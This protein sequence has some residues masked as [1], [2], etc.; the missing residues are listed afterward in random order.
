[1]PVTLETLSPV[2]TDTPAHDATPETLR[3]WACF[4]GTDIVGASATRQIA[5]RLLVES[6]HGRIA[7][8]SVALREVPDTSFAARLA[9]LIDERA[10][11]LAS[12]ERIAGEFG[13][14][15]GVSL[16]VLD[17]DLDHDNPA[18]NSGLLAYVLAASA[19]QSGS[20]STILVSLSSLRSELT[21]RLEHDWNAMRASFIR[22]LDAHAVDTA[23][24]INGLRPSA[25]NYLGPTRN[26]DATADTLAS[27]VATV[28]QA[29]RVREIDSLR[30][31]SSRDSDAKRESD[32]ATGTPAWKVDAARQDAHAE[33]P[34][35]SGSQDGSDDTRR[36]NRHQALVAFPFLQVL[37]QRP[38]FKPVCQ[39][40]D[41]GRPLV[42]ALADH[43]GATRG[44]IRT[45]HGV[46]ASNLG[47][48]TSQLGILLKLLRDL[49]SAWWPRDPD[50]WRRF[51]DTVDRIVRIS[52]HPITT[53]TN[54]LWLRR[55]LQSGGSLPAVTPEDLVRLGRDIDEFLDTL[56]AAIFSQMA[57]SGRRAPRGSGLASIQVLGH[58]KAS[59]GLVRLSELVR[60]FGDA[61]LRAVTVFASQVDLWRGVRWPA[62]GDGPLT[63]GEVRLVPLLTPDDLRR[64][65][66]QMRNCVANYVERCAKGA[67]QFW[68]VRH[69]D[70]I[71]LSTLETHLISS[72]PGRYSLTIAQ[73]KGQGNGPVPPIAA[74]AAQAHIA[75]LSA[76]P[77]LM[78][79][80]LDWRETISRQPL[81]LR[82]RRAL[83]IPVL[84]A[85]EGTLPE[86]WSLAK[87]IELTQRLGIGNAS[88]Q[89]LDAV[90]DAYTNHG[91][92]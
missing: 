78:Q 38:A 54:Q 34:S 68:S 91:V 16:E 14:R 70:G 33:H 82:H 72:P 1:M 50:H 56:R 66:E 12:R 88:G 90:L 6:R 74:A 67:S 23:R 25:Y 77:N 28:R 61:Y 49:P 7:I 2:D 29:T 42:D 10:F 46:N 60:R 11:R 30:P 41:G 20:E 31:H 83:M 3:Q 32:T 89:Q 84:S 4:P 52:R 92:F 19:R 26:S 44:L 21:T 51:I 22:E 76:A 63:Y 9:S 81:E 80:Y 8:A 13:E 69:V 47:R 85:L 36:R 79:V 86:R 27:K 39:A 43:Y 37:V 87:L 59:L 71:P 75:R 48:W 5:F 64:E 35:I 18:H 40:I 15:H 58:F 17:I 53:S 24:K 73:H 57:A 65:G 45:L 55:V 62:I